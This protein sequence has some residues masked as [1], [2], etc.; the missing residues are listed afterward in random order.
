MKKITFIVVLLFINLSLFS[1]ISITGK[2]IDVN[3][4]EPLPVATIQIVGT[5]IGTTTDFDGLFSLEV[6]SEA[7]VL[8]ISFIGY[9]P[10]T[11][12]VGSNVE[13]TI[14][15]EE[16]VLKLDEVVVTALGIKREKKA[17]GYAVQDVKGDEL[18]EANPDNVVSALS[19]RVAGAQIV[20][21]SGQLGSSSTIKLRGNKTFMGNNQP[22]FVVDGTP[23]IN[24][25]NTAQ[26]N[27]TYTDFGNAAMDIDPSEIESISVLKGA[28]ASALYGSRAANGVVLIT[29]K[30]GSQ[31]KGLGVE[32]STSFDFS[33]VYILPD[34]QNDYGQGRN[35]SEYE[36]QNNYADLTY[37]EFHDKREFRW[38]TDGSGYRMDWDESWGSRLDAGLMVAQMDSPLDANGNVIPT[39]WVSHPDNVKDYYETGMSTINNLALTSVTDKSQTRLTLA[40]SGQKGTSPNTNQK[41]L[42]IGLKTHNDLTDRLSFDVNFNYGNLV[43]KPFYITSEGF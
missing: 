2:V 21:S 43:R 29:T 36:W 5:T 8:K 39:P 23:I 12:T 26:S 6:R 14:P 42:N 24:S 41:K 22:L 3:T 9:L 17:L 35:G 37:Q 18:E 15:L 32:F 25:I 16:D 13:F 30:K 20:T 4:G 19:G 34:Y 33:N 11:I 28:S 38:A 7:D 1:Q 31:K 40:Y 10:A 27:Q